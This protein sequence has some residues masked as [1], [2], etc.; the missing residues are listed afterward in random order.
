[1][2]SGVLIPEGRIQDDFLKNLCALFDIIRMGVP[3]AMD[4]T[5]TMQEARELGLLEVHSSEQAS[6]MAAELKA[7]LKDYDNLIRWYKDGSLSSFLKATAVKG[8][9]ETRWEISQAIKDMDQNNPTAQNSEGIFL[10]ILLH[11]YQETVENKKQAELDLQSLGVSGSPLAEAL[12]EDEPVEVLEPAKD[13]EEIAL[14]IDEST[15]REVLRGWVTLF[16]SVLRPGDIIITVNP[17]VFAF[18]T[19]QFEEAINTDIA[20]AKALRVA[21]FSLPS[22]AHVPLKDLLSSRISEFRQ[23]AGLLFDLVGR[24]PIE[25]LENLLNEKK[26]DLT[27]CAQELFGSSNPIAYRLRLCRLP[28]IQERHLGKNEFLSDLSGRLIVNMEA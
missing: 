22:C 1:M 3:L 5:P 19:E 17:Q 23:K 20:S 24:H 10:Q 26:S 9:E 12:G 8:Q 15:L 4:P 13:S 27:Q 11:L 18:I 2:S 16:P 25:D 21:I 14:P 28:K 7:L 6:P